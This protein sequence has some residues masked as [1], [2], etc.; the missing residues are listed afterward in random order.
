METT[1]LVYSIILGSLMDFVDEGHFL[2]GKVTTS[3]GQVTT[4]GG[5]GY[6]PRGQEHF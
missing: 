4:L 6:K 1:Y 3:A 2:V 5:Q